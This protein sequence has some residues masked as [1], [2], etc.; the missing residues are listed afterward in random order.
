LACMV[1]RRRQVVNMISTEQ[2]R[3]SAASNYS[4]DSINKVLSF[5]RSEL[6]SID[7]DISLHV[8]SHFADISGLLASFK[9]IGPA[10]IG[11]LLGE[12]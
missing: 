9:G 12:V 4:T 5:L 10:T 8:R 2:Q 1:A 7:A 11:V 6:K 3:K